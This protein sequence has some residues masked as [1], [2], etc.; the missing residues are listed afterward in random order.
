MLTTFFFLFVSIGFMF[1]T[2]LSEE[3]N[4]DLVTNYYQTT[5]ALL[6]PAE[7]P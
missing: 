4:I 5:L 3:T 1:A 7:Y 6:E 2:R